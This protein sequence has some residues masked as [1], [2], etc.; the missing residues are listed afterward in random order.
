MAD[1]AWGIVDPEDSQDVLALARKKAYAQALMQQSMQ[2]Q[3]P[4]QTAGKYV[5]PYSPLQGFAQL[6]KGALGGALA[7]Q[8]DTEEATAK[9]GMM[10]KRMALVKQL[11]PQLSDQEAQA[12]ASLNVGPE[13]LL[14][15]KLR[16]TPE[17]KETWSNLTPD[18][19]KAQG[20]RTGS[21]VRASNT[22]KQEVVQAPRDTSGQPSVDPN[23]IETVAQGIANGQLAPLSGYASRSPRA[24][25]IMARVLEINPGYRGTD[26]GSMAAAEKFWTSGKG[27]N[28]VRSLNVANAHLDTL[29]GLIDALHNN[30]IQTFNKIGNEF[31]KQTGGTAPTNFDAAKRIVSDEIVK[32]IVGAG[33]ALAD[34]E[35]ASKSISN[36]QSPE[37]LRGVIKT[38]QD[39]MGG[40][41]SGL[42]QQ[43]ES[44]TGR[45]DFQDRFLMKPAKQ[46]TAKPAGGITPEQARAELA[47][48]RAAK[49]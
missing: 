8:A 28:T 11:A 32:A 31:A 24:A 25:K 41:L 45:K 20:Y 21:I 26:Y 13:K 47:R 22:G 37:Q 33:G 19:L 7:K 15:A 43:Y 6:A 10:S 2:Q 4:T 23:D 35:E 44:G 14:E 49:K 18:Q 39:L 34:R 42:A 29:G 36:A 5:V 9:Q 48:R 46:E 27:A 17:P 3:D 38:Y 30:D 1:Q 12:Y 40:Q 16:P